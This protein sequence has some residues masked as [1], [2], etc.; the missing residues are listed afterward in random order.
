MPRGEEPPEEDTD[1]QQLHHSSHAPSPQN[2]NNTPAAPLVAQMD[3]IQIQ[4][5]LI[6]VQAHATMTQAP[7]ITEVNLAIRTAGTLPGPSR[8]RLPL[9]PPGGGW[10]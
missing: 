1:E 3:N 7:I 5:D 8:N 6:E 4:H 9:G 10:P 2:A